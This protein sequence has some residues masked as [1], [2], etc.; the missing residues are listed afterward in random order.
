MAPAPSAPK[1]RRWFDMVEEDDDEFVESEGSSS[2]RSYSDVVRDGTPSPERSVSPPSPQGGP[3]AARSPP[4]RQLATVVFRLAQPRA[5][6]GDASRGVGGRRGP[7]PKRQRRR[8]PLPSFFVPAGVPAGLAGL[9]FNCAEPGHVAGRCEGPLRFLNCKSETHIARQCTAPGA[10]A[11]GAPPPPP[12]PV[13]AS[14]PALPRVFPAPPPPRSGA[15]APTAAQ[16]V[17][18][19]VPSYRVPARQRLGLVET[20]APPVLLRAPV[21]ERLGSRV[22]PV[23]MQEAPAAARPVT[24][25]YEPVG[26]E[27]PYESG[28]RRERELRAASPLRRDEVARG[29]TLLDRSSRRELELQE[30]A[31]AS[32]ARRPPLANVRPDEE[33]VAEFEAARPARERCIIYRTPEVDD[34]EHALRWGVVAFVSGTRHSVTSE[35]AAAVLG[36]FPALEGHFSVHRFWLAE[37]LLVFDSRANRDALLAA[38]PLDARDFSLRF[39]LWNRQRQATRHVF[40]FRVHLEVVGIPPVA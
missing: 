18:P 25:A 8:A 37:F 33:I 2:R 29:E 1:S 21:K 40:R 26:D 23:G 13:A 39:G 10:V 17:E 11:V 7:Q 9:C 4:A 28:L 15:G 24:H 31:L 14:P 34:V 35:A 38:N 19:P 30:A 6:G 5:D 27:T 12:P 3:V 20:V 32:A 22:P 16:P 36:H